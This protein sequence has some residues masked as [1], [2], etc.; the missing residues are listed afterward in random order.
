MAKVCKKDEVDYREGPADNNA[1]FDITGCTV[2]IMEPSKGKNEIFNE[3]EYGK[4]S[5]PLSTDLIKGAIIQAYDG[6]LKIN[7]DENQK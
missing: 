1:K 4:K 3:E 6:G 7:K 5:S 2:E